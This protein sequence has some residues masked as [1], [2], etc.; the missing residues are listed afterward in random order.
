MYRVGNLKARAAPSGDFS[1][2]SSGEDCSST[3][4][5][6]KWAAAAQPLKLAPLSVMMKFIH[7][8][9]MNYNA[10]HLHHIFALRASMDSTRM[11][12]IAAF[13]AV[14]ETGSFTAAARVEGRDASILSRRVS[15]LETN[16]G[17]RFLDRSTRHVSPTS[18]SLRF[19]QRIRAA[20]AAMH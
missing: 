17:E 19:Y 2:E 12:Q 1:A 18:A 9:K 10:A 7:S 3:T 11:D 15:A 16:L 14:V 5:L 13:L 6:S 8:C 20:L 4:S